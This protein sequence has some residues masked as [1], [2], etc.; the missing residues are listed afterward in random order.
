M[1]ASRIRSLTLKFQAPHTLSPHL[2]IFLLCALSHSS[3][4]LDTIV[5]PP[6]AVLDL[7][8]RARRCLIPGL[9]ACHHL[10]PGLRARYRRPPPQ[11]IDTVTP[12]PSSSSS[13]RHYRT[14]ADDLDP[15]LPRYQALN[16]FS[17]GFYYM[18]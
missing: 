5:P 13:P 2:A 12:P 15:N 7:G 17:S 14:A 1:G 11:A 6:P 8:P 18:I 4:A 16:S 10:D 3:V 9:R